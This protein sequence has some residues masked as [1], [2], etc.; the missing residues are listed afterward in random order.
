MQDLEAVWD[1]LSKNRL[2]EYCQRHRPPLPFPEYSTVQ[3][4]PPHIPTFRVR[5]RICACFAYGPHSSL[6]SASDSSRLMLWFSV[7]LHALPPFCIVG[8]Y[9]HPLAPWDI[10]LY[11]SP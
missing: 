8:E 9:R 4:G 6:S 2:Q 3:S 5:S 1:S 7:A 10:P 11:S